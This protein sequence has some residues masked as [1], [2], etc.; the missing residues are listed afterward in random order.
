MTGRKTN[1]VKDRSFNA[2]AAELQRLFNSL[3]RLWTNSNRQ[4]ANWRKAGKKYKEIFLNAPAGIYQA[5]YEGKFLR[6]N[7]AVAR[8]LGYDSAEEIIASITDIKRQLYV[9]PEER[10]AF[11]NAIQVRGD[12]SG[13]E[14]QF[15]S[16]SGAKVWISV[17]ARIIYDAEQR[18]LYMEGFLTDINARKKAEPPCRK[19]MLCWRVRSRNGRRHWLLPIWS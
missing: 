3:H 5:S 19:R 15:F 1:W 2:M 13:H 14:L 18:P 17:A 7:P 10:E 8:I 12:V 16:K 6:A 9:H 11:L 4:A